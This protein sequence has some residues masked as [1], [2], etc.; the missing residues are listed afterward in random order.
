[1]LI[2]EPNK[3][4]IMV[5]NREYGVERV[6]PPMAARA[7]PPGSTP[8]HQRNANVPRPSSRIIFSNP[9]HHL[10]QSPP[11]RPARRN[12]IGHVNP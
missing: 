10:I 3:M 4:Q 6:V 8:A 9:I 1:M 2:G 7:Y 5:V 11:L 12:P